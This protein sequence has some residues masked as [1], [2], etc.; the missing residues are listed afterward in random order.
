MQDANLKEI[1]NL[2]I[3]EDTDKA[4][5]L[6]H[7]WFVEQTKAVHENMM[8]EDDITSS[9]KDDQDAVKAEEFYGESDLSDD[10]GDDD[11]D[12]I[13]SEAAADVEDGS[14]DDDGLDDISDEIPA[15]VTSVTTDP[16]VIKDQ[17][18]DLQADLARLQKEFDM[19]T[20]ADTGL[21]DDMSDD[22]T[23]DSMDLEN[24][25]ESVTEDADSDMDDADA[26]SDADAG[27]DGD[28]AGEDDLDE[29]FFSDL[30]FDELAEAVAM[31]PV[32]V[33]T[34]DGKEVG[35]EG[36]IS[37]NKKSTLPQKTMTNRQGGTPVKIKSEEHSGFAREKSPTTK[38]N[39]TGDNSNA[40][41]MDGTSKVPSKGD[42]KAEL[43]KTQGKVNDKSVISGTPKK[44][45]V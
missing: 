41:F 33:S 3:N 43:N 5:V 10:E 11:S 16:D 15:D 42:S 45:G 25:E 27:N 13:D 30:D 2:I 40:C 9:I 31:K 4:N 20:G 1:L 39:K 28:N 8:Q 12:D 26:D 23:D 19:M 32:K 14:S 6:L 29:S 21:S 17:F 38:S 35:A 34:K 36:T 7:Q 22:M 18:S 44:K 24:T 37:Q